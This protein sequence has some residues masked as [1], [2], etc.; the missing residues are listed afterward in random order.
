M[1][2]R[3]KDATRKG[4]RKKIQKKINKNEEGRGKEKRIKN[5]R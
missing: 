4:R 1:K 5:V 3:M 2:R